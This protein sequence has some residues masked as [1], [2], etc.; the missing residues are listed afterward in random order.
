MFWA[1]VRLVVV[2][3]GAIG[4]FK[5]IR[6]ICEMPR[7]FEGAYLKRQNRAKWGRLG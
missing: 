3:M 4:E 1:D 6:L 7:I 2:K 5:V